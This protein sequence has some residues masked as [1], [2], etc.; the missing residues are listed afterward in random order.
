ML[1]CLLVAVDLVEQY[2]MELRAQM[3]A[4]PPHVDPHM[5]GLGLQPGGQQDTGPAAGTEQSLDGPQSHGFM[6]AEGG[7]DTRGD[8]WA[9]QPLPL[10][11]VAGTLGPF[12]PG[13]SLSGHQGSEHVPSS[14][15]VPGFSGTPELRLASTSG[16][17]QP[18]HSH[19]GPVLSQLAGTSATGAAG[20]DEHARAHAKGQRRKQHGGRGGMPGRGLPGMR[21]TPPKG[22][23]VFVSTWTLPK[24]Q[25]A[26]TTASLLQQQHQREQLPAAG[27][28][29]A[30]TSGA[31]S[32]GYSQ[33]PRT[34][35]A[36][37]LASAPLSPL[38]HAAQTPAGPAVLVS[39]QMQKQQRSQRPSIT[40]PLPHSPSTTP[41][42]RS[43]TQA[44]PSND[45]A[46]ASGAAV[47]PAVATTTSGVEPSMAPLAPPISTGGVAARQQAL[48][49]FGHGM[50]EGASRDVLRARTGEEPAA[51]PKNS[52]ATATEQTAPAVQPQTD[53]YQA[54]T[55][56]RTTTTLPV[57]ATPEQ[58]GVQDAAEIDAGAADTAP[59]GLKQV[60]SAAIEPPSA[61]MGTLVQAAGP[62]LQQAPPPTDSAGIAAIEQQSASM[63]TLAPAGVQRAAGPSLPQ[64]S[65]PTDI[66]AELAAQEAAGEGVRA[67]EGSPSAAPAGTT[68][69]QV[70]EVQPQGAG[71]QIEGPQDE[72]HPPQDDTM[73]LED[74]ASQVLDDVVNDVVQDLAMELPGA[75]KPASRPEE[76]EGM[77]SGDGPAVDHQAP[78]HQLLGADDQAAGAQGS[79][80]H[81]NVLGTE[82]EAED[83]QEAEPE[84]EQV[85]QQVLDPQLAQHQSV[86][87]G[88]RA[89]KQPVDLQPVTDDQSPSVHALA[90]TSQHPVQAPPIEPP[91]AG[92]CTEMPAASAAIY[93][94]PAP[95]APDL[96]ASGQPDPAAGQ[97]T[98]SAS[99]PMLQDQ[100][101]PN[102]PPTVLI[103]APGVT[104]TRGSRSARLPGL[105]ESQRSMQK[106]QAT[107]ATQLLPA[108]PMVQA[109]RPATVQRFGM[110]D[111]VGAES[112]ALLL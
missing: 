24:A 69:G 106:R 4:T 78:D 97:Q 102:E 5:D 83:Q 17:V 82:P 90:G 34:P 2:I 80:G 85:D 76:S 36:A 51:G 60:P 81:K 39:Q 77:V 103:H 58:T 99:L 13:G 79:E 96:A 52:A 40:Q 32:Q 73:L 19:P 55:S 64:A 68:S 109:A 87:E 26:S 65:P 14:D 28:K 1:S 12:L 67:T 42:T 16:P 45:L 101:Q 44:R 111:T 107:P 20:S 46:A 59:G 86:L 63:G 84:P 92:T 47:G 70:M 110:A 15:H 88:Q 23:A 7:G 53:G 62:S 54:T 66:L 31:L 50:P 27:A 89:H 35:T 33:P 95:S 43:V 93:P 91:T 72:P 48:S 104:L 98:H 74:P 105:I 49:A 56:A 25:I 41:Q 29:R 3:A 8:V 100:L 57:G 94:D 22:S 108:L 10:P 112:A 6:L 61:S 37:G 18:Q 11:S 21:M 38:P 71:A 75:S 30:R 9:M